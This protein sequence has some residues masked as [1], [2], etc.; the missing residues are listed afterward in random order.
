MPFDFEKGRVFLVS[1]PPSGLE[2][3]TQL[4]IELPQPWPPTYEQLDTM[5]KTIV[6]IK[7]LAYPKLSAMR[8]QQPGAAAP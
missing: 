6:P 7:D 2:V 4:A 8:L 3:V 1:R 5:A